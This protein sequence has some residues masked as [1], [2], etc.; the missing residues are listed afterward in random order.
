M[1]EM[2]FSDRVNYFIGPLEKELQ[3]RIKLEKPKNMEYLYYVAQDWARTMAAYMDELQPDHGET[4]K[5][6]PLLI[7]KEKEVSENEDEFD[8]IK[9]RLNSMDMQ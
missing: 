4:D 2:A 6:L 8:V 1:K 3:R 5:A 9:L 7:K